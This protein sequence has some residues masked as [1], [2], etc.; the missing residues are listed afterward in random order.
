MKRK[1]RNRLLSISVVALA[2]GAVSPAYAYSVYRGVTANAETG[3]VVWTKDNFGVS[4][5]PVPTLSFFYYADDAAA[6]AG[7]H[8]A[9]C[10]VKVDWPNVPVPAP[11]VAPA[12]PPQANVGIAAADVAGALPFPWLIDFD[13]NPQGHWSIA[14]GAIVADNPSNNAA[15]GVAAL[16]FKSLATTAGS[17]VTVITGTL[18]SL[19][20]P[21]TCKAQ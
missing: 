1:H 4:G 20:P 12:P 21:V 14:K 5:N 11:A 13:N 19:V 17:N 7:L 2:L 9:Q 3:V 16:G 15:S 10:L 8:S 18:G 6:V